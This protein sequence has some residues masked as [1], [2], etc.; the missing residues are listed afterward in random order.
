[1]YKRERGRESKRE[2]V[3]M[4]EPV[5]SQSKIIIIKIRLSEKKIEFR[6]RIKN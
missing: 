4:G 1:M 6:K 3:R 5:K 2:G